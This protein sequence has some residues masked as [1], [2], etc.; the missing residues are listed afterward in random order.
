MS[1]IVCVY[2]CGGRE[3]GSG[4]SGEKERVHGAYTCI[5]YTRTISYYALR[6]PNVSQGKVK[7][8]KFG[9][10]E[11]TRQIFQYIGK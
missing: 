9:D 4:G 7:L 8:N 3:G 2:M 1:M 10:R 6:I 11:P 5:Y